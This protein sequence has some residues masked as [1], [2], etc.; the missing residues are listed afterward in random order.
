VRLILTGLLLAPVL[1]CPGEANGPGRPVPPY[2]G[3]ATELFDDVIEPKA[4][5]MEI[6]D[7]LDPRGDPVLRERTQIGD[8]TLRVRVDTVTVKQEDQ[9]ATYQ[10][11]FRAIDKLAGK[12]PPGDAF[13][14]R[15]SKSSQG[16]VKDLESQLVGKRFI[17]FVR[18]FGVDG[19]ERELHFH[20]SPDSK[21]V[22][23]AVHDA[24]V[25]G[26]MR[27]D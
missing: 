5:G 1:G 22:A 7:T 25:L 26:E 20:L 27:G 8:A 10:I 19:G 2:H 14:V 13:T 18:L 6:G 17:I 23:A 11:G 24:T 9:G 12:F 3:H 4:V 21:Q 15:P 16:L